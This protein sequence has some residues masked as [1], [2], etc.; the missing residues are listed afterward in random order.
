MHLQFRAKFGYDAPEYEASWKLVCCDPGRQWQ[1]Q[2]HNWFEYDAHEMVKPKTRG[3][4]SQ[5]LK[6]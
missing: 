1:T 6:R 3:Y 2:N 4:V 5:N